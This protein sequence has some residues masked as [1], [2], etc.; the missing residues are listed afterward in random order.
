MDWVYESPLIHRVENA[1]EG[2]ESPGFGT[3]L[4]GRAS[5]TDGSCSQSKV[6]AT[7]SLTPGQTLPAYTLKVT[8]H[9]SLQHL[10]RHPQVGAA[11][12][13]GRVTN[14]LYVGPLRAF[15]D[16][17]VV[18]ELNIDSL[19]CVAAELADAPLPA[20]LKDLPKL[21]IPLRDAS[22]ED[23]MPAVHR[24]VNYVDTENGEGRTV[25]VYCQAGKSRSVAI[26]IGYLLL[27]PAINGD[28]VAAIVSPSEALADLQTRYPHADPNVF[29]MQQ[30]HD[31]LSPTASSPS[32]QSS[33]KTA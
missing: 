12:S 24:A 25:G 8:R 26:A 3:S 5:E 17:S 21:V 30:L 19:L 20:H 6:D 10:S 16:E 9:A 28:G 32:V 29:F 7:A 2:D 4:R 11:T 18:R 23:L 22:D 27:R 31:H 13:I 33:A 15:A 1:F 14:R